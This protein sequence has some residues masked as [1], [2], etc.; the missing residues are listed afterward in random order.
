MPTTQ[1]AF[2]SAHLM[3]LFG[4][5]LLFGATLCICLAVVLR[6]QILDLF[7]APHGTFFLRVL[8]LFFIVTITGNL[9]LLRIL[10]PSV[11]AA[12]FG[13][14]LG[15]VFGTRGNRAESRHSPG[16]KSRPSA[17]AEQ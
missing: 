6:A 16:R 5:Q 1:P 13:S 12:I 10:E 4:G 3:W 9:T 15:Y 14:V 17:D 11:A 7:T 8:T 2:E